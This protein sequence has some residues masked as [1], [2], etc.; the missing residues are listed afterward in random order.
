VEHDLETASQPQ[1][2]HHEH[3]VPQKDLAIVR[4]FLP[5]GGVQGRLPP[6]T[7]S[8]MDEHE[9]GFAVLARGAD[10]IK[11]AGTGYKTQGSAG[12]RA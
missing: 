10:D 2:R 4:V 11:L 1:L 3:V 5:H 7:R 6:P 9:G 12:G 8:T